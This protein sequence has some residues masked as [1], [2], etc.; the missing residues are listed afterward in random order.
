MLRDIFKEMEPTNKKLIFPSQEFDAIPVIDRATG[1]L[2]YII[3]DIV[4][5]F[6]ES[7]AKLTGSTK[8]Q[9]IEST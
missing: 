2:D 7:T 9:L 1:V 4:V 6:N 8:L 3:G 5:S